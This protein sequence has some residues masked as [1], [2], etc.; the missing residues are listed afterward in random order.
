[1]GAILDCLFW[2]IISFIVL[3]VLISTIAF[4]RWRAEHRREIE[5]QAKELR[6]LGSWSDGGK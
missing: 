2:P 6:S 5:R 4:L 1:M 3:G